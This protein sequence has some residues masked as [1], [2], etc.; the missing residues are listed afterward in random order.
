MITSSVPFGFADH[1]I[2]IQEPQNLESSS[3][4][5]SKII[6]VS[7]DENIGLATNRPTDKALAGQTNVNDTFDSST[8]LVSFYESLSINSSI[9]EGIFDLILSN[10]I[11]LK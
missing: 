5:Q 6:S 4:I 10:N 11:L 8:K 7:L 1:H 3:S 2:D 9:I